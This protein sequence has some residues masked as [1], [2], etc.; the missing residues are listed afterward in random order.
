MPMPLY[1]YR[2]ACGAEFETLVRTSSQAD[3]QS[4]PTCGADHVR[5][6]LSVFSAPRATGSDGAS[7]MGAGEGCCGG[8]CGSC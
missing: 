2:C 6:L 5:R 3:E 4:C 8:A 7:M 1:E